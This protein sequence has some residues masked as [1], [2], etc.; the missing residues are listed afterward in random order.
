MVNRAFQDISQALNG[1]FVFF[2]SFDVLRLLAPAVLEFTLQQMDLSGV[3]RDSHGD[4]LEGHVSIETRHINWPNFN[5]IHV[6]STS[7]DHTL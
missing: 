7:F 4:S 6:C 2:G 5:H 3:V 1:F